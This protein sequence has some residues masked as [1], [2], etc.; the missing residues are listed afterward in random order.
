MLDLTIARTLNHYHF[1]FML[2]PLFRL[3]VTNRLKKNTFIEVFSSGIHAA[4]F[5]RWRMVNCNHYC[6][7]LSW[8]V[9]FTIKLFVTPFTLI[10][11]VNNGC[12]MVSEYM[13]CHSVLLIAQ[14]LCLFLQNIRCNV[15][16]CVKFHWRFSHLLINALFKPWWCTINS[17]V[18][19][20]WF[21]NRYYFLLNYCLPLHSSLPTCEQ[22]MGLQRPN[23]QQQSSF[24]VSHVMSIII[25]I[26][27]FVSDF[28]S[29]H[30][31]FLHL[32]YPLRDHFQ[33]CLISG[34]WSYLHTTFH[35]NCFSSLRENS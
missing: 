33:D 26:S 14:K 20:V 24:Y 7:F 35:I 21:C 27:A 11:N 13:H 15:T 34:I 23:R 16:V 2:G 4:F 1:T 25:I 8:T 28:V 19:C 6:L 31:R 3:C 30:Y 32:F 29:E 18:N 5:I 17:V 10:I 9:I 22:R 12:I